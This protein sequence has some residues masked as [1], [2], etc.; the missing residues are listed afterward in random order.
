MRA[1]LDTAYIS[2][3]FLDVD[4]ATRLCV[5]VIDRAA[6]TATELIEEPS[7]VKKTDVQ[8]LLKK[9]RELLV[10]A[11]LLVLSGS[12]APGV[13]ATFYRDCVA[14]AAEHKCG[15]SS[16]PPASRSRNRSRPSRLW[17]SRTDRN[18]PYARA[19]DRQRE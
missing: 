1:D 19:D 14:L 16:T 3:A 12:L 6:H 4:A 9:L 17:S 2:H 10:P 18:S 13:P 7:A 15:R 11:S 8:L 5:T